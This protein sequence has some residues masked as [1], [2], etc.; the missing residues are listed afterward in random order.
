MSFPRLP[1]RLLVPHPPRVGAPWA[2]LFAVVITLLFFAV[3]REI[4]PFLS[5]VPFFLFALSVFLAA[6][7]GGRGP[8][9]VAVA[10]AAILVD[11]HF[12]PPENGGSTSPRALLLLALFVLVFTVVNMLCGALR[13]AVEEAES[14][15][16]VLRYQLDLNTG[17]AQNAAEAIFVT[18]D[19]GRITFANREA[20]RLFGLSCEELKGQ[21][22][23][24]RFH[25]HGPDGRALPA[26]EC[27]LA[28]VNTS[29][30][31]IREHEETFFRKEG[32]AVSVS[33]SS[34]PLTIEGSRTGAVLIA[35][36]ISEHKRAEEALRRERSLL[37]SV[38]QA[39]DVM[40]AYLDA[41]FNFVWVNAAYAATCNLR[42]E[43]M[44]GKNHFALYP[45]A[46]NEAIF[47]RV[48]DTAG[49]VF[50]KD[51]PFEFPDQ[52]ERGV[53]YWDWSLVPVKVPTGKVHGLVFSLRE[54]TRYKEAELALRVSEERFR[55]LIEVSAQIVWVTNAA[56][57]PTEDSP[58]WRAFTGRTLEQWLGWN[59]LEV[60]HPDDRARVAEVW[61]GALA[62]RSEYVVEFRM[63]NAAQEYRTVVARAVPIANPDGSIREWVGM[64]TDITERKRAEASARASQ[65][66]LRSTMDHFPTAIAFKDRE[67]RFLDVNPAV[68]K[69]LGLPKDEIL[70]RAMGAFVP[71]EA[72]RVLE[73]HDED[74]MASRAARLYEELTPLPAETL[75]R[76]DTNFPLIDA[77]GDVYG[78][79]HISLDVTEL[80][81]TE[82]AL[83][84]A[85]EKL[86]EADRRKN[87]F[88]AMLSHELRNP[89]AP[90][91][92]SLYILE[93]SAPGGEQAER[94]QAVIARQVE[95]MTRLIEDLLDVSR[96]SRGKVNLHRERLDL[97]RLAQRTVEDH[98][99]V[100]VKG[101]VQLVVLPAPMAVWVNGDRTR[102]AQAL[103]NLLQ[104]AAKFT[105]VGGETTVT[106]GADAA[107]SQGVLT[108]RDTGSG[109]DPRIMPRLF[110]A[111]LQADTTLE[112]SKG[113]LGLG[114]S[115]VK[116]L[117]EQH[118]GSVSASSDGPGKGSTFV[119]R[120]PLDT[121]VAEVS[122]ERR[123][124]SAG[125]LTLRILIVEH[126]IDS[127]D[128]LREA[129]ELSDHV[130]EVAHS[131]PEGLSKAR[132]FRPDV[133]LCD[134][135]LPGMDGYEVAR[136]FKSDERVRGCF[137][138]AISGY[139]LPTD[140]KRASEAGFQRHLAKPPS[141]EKLKLLLASL[142][143]P[144]REAEGGAGMN[145]EEH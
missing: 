93:R 41:D 87:E 25:H 92:N 131:G 56:G 79:G 77:S 119:V 115:L 126:N 2:Y 7:V 31:T 74:V 134:I 81:R 76:I 107:R 32:S 42:P 89:L 8:G 112:R 52:P 51:K 61:R 1:R 23:H 101:Q 65:Q 67:G 75:Y 9:F 59:W 48:R 124:A 106:I 33:C 109:I 5:R 88:I 38:M 46:E 39:T 21:V 104:N 29:G 54:T 138:V 133:L 34:S 125:G 103:G 36:D 6:W 136:A 141:L 99:S 27:P 71:R 73:G 95:H 13:D 68:E 117:V 91:R 47:R 142:P 120:I 121:S 122:P 3:Q 83:R 45:H 145:R 113:G 84:E 10:L 37:E 72:A 22:L 60:V 15:A 28:S 69:A 114:L 139:A 35:R 140:L 53:T 85:N 12:L 70:G 100:F 143:P 55:R 11:Y 90:I 16:R 78:T 30:A 62:A 129:L 105:P 24:D 49:P 58:S 14:G 132:R 128:S 20:E 44:L 123:L 18:D 19:R 102:I 4:A 111:F 94:A 80:K 64:N 96:I 130:V 50:Y 144:P 43:E 137:L 26:S 57:E 63:L 97:N 116:G 66:L 82:L 86:R 40:L 118:G 108:V 98:R 110:E 135:G 127:A 17:I